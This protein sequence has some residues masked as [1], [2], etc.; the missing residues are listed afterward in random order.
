MFHKSPSKTRAH[1]LRENARLRAQLAEAEETLRA[2]HSGEVDA[3]VVSSKDGDQVFTLRG[4]DHPYRVL[5]EDMNEGALTVTGDGVILYANQRFAE[6]VR[7]PLEKVIGSVID[8]WIE[9]SDQKL[10]H[11]LLRR[12]DTQAHYRGEIT[13]LAS[14][15]GLV[16]GYF[17]TNFLRKE[18]LPELFCLVAT[19]LTEQKR[20]EAIV[21]AEKLARSIL[22]QAAEAIVV[23]DEKGQIMRAS[24][25]AYGLCSENP[26][27]QP[28][29]CAFPLQQADGPLFSLAELV[30]TGNRSRI[31]A[32]LNRNGEVLD[33]LVSIGPLLGSHRVRLGS[34]IALI[35]ITERKRTE[36]ALSRTL[37]ELQTHQFEL[38][39]QNEELKQAHQELDASRAKYFDLYDLAP[40]GYIT[41]STKGMILDANLTAASLLNAKRNDLVKYPL[42]RFILEED[43]AINYA[44]LKRL[45][46][47]RTPQMCEL[48]VVGKNGALRWV[49]ID[50]KVEQSNNGTPVFWET[51][52]DI[53]ERKQHD[54]ELEAVVLMSAALRGARTRIEMLPIIADQVTNLVDAASVALLSNDAQSN[55]FVIEY[56]QGVWADDVGK[57]LP[58]TVGILHQVLADGKPYLTNDLPN[59]AHFF[60][61]D[62]IRGVC[63]FIETPLATQEAVIGFLGVASYAPF[64]EQD[65]RVLTAISDIAANAI[66]RAALHEQTEQ[67]AA[68]LTQAYDATLEGWAHALEL[69]D[70][71]TEGHTRRVVQL[72]VELA[73]TMGFTASALEHIRRGALLHDIGKMGVPDS[74]LLKPGTLNDR[75]WE[76]MRRHP[77][78]AYKFLSPIDYLQPALDI[79][80]CHHEKWDG[81]GYPR[82]LKGEEIPLVARIFAIIDVWDALCSDRPYRLA[83]KREAVIEYL[84]AQ[85]GKHFDPQIVDA[86]LAFLAL[87]G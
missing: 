34:V 55:D 16:P 9:P 85:R 50:A 71:E 31:E 86:F 19:D 63:A 44:H 4:A 83:W 41:L 42:S 15:G 36:A 1:L 77:E 60:Y 23:C 61:R 45:F 10:F 12:D 30:D 25:A 56:V 47:T 46:K 68:D 8:T 70:Q 65:V 54:R 66:H 49:R 7:T 73:Q 40:V 59:D 82:G 28:F 14:D 2:I 24:A 33:L 35:D 75:E 22:E 57:R 69:R 20:N 62:S 21:A 37:F 18:D 76:I 38:Q 5:I 79:P 64:T 67:Y 87:R 32:K 72:T 3:V 48:R 17:S 74:V 80:Y 52:T 13:I 11:A 29:A 26:L 27:G 53:T 39:M 58:R 78:Y 6:M 84:Q 51:L 81:T 43:Q